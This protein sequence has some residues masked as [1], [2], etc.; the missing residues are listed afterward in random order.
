MD[1]FFEH[2][3][4]VGQQ[5]LVLFILIAF[6]F[7]LGKRGIMG[8]KGAKVCADIALL[9]ATP[10][11]IIKSF[12]RNVTTEMLWGL[13]AALGV[14]AL[15]HFVGIGM[16]HLLFRRATPRDRVLRLAT[17]L[18]N[19]GFMGLPLQEAV[20]GETGVFYG[21]AYVVM[22]NLLLWSY[23]QLTMDEQT[24]KLSWRKLLINPGTIGLG[25]GLVVLLVPV[26]LPAVI[27]SPV[28]HLAAL[29]TP[30]P[31]LFIG[32]RLSRVE[33]SKA[34]RRPIHF[35]ASAVR[36][37]LVPVL[38]GAL[39]LAFGIRGTL[40]VSMM[41]AAS[42]PVAAAVSMFANRYEQ[43]SETAANLVAVSTVLSLVTMPL[44]VALA[45][46]VSG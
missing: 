31:M 27:A 41:I 38:S 46:V 34:W 11:V 42:A 29:N 5:V 30:L 19:A 14:S 12:Q 18:S 13:L 44:L 40:F 45:Q 8:E 35:T 2:F 4:T 33:L 22:F 23:G 21:A 25:L 24:Q 1:R 10:C 17:V 37:I 16:G 7:V 32:Y 3:L 36:L 26:D 6:G 9:L 28:A 43:D 39:L 20:L 15:I